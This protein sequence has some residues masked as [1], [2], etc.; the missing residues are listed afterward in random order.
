MLLLGRSRS[1]TP[2]LDDFDIGSAISRCGTMSNIT[3]KGSEAWVV[4]RKT[5]WKRDNKK[6]L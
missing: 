6:I 3:P 1:G 4:G 2:F 5:G